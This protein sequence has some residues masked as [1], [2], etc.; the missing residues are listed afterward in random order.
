[1]EL[2]IEAGAAQITKYGEELC[3]DNY[4]LI[5]TAD[6]VI[7]VL[8][9]GL[10]SGVKANILATLT[11][12]ILTT[13][14]ENDCNLDEV[15]AT[16]GHTLPICQVRKVAYSTFTIARIYSD[17]RAY[18]AEFD[19]PKAF[20]LR[21]GRVRALERSQR[22]IDDKVVQE[23]HFQ[24]QEGDHLIFASDGV[25]HAGVGGV[26]NLGWRWESVAEYIERLAIEE[27]DAQAISDWLVMVT[28]QLYVHR[29]GDDA[30]VI[31]MKARAPRSTTVL[32]GPPVNPS[33]DHTVVRELLAEQGKKV[34]CGGT[35]SNI[36]ARETG[37]SISVNLE[38]LTR[39][40]PPTGKIRGIDLVTEGIMTLAKALKLL[41]DRER[42]SSLEDANDGA[43][44]LAH[45]LLS[46]DHVSFLVGRAIN[47]AHQSPS[48]PINLALKMKIVDELSAELA[49]RGK[50]VRMSYY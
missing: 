11:T 18:L 5:R 31:T 7:A 17:G 40:V 43:S 23:A 39:E 22:V 45:V 24:V 41:K 38:T 27:K 25:I 37:S 1:M 48:H 42:Q 33:D 3:G 50:Q 26:L 30:T 8:S 13:M 28:D 10:G 2:F 15:I 49:Q 29:P 46:S 34:V 44:Q 32:V 47:P 21:G 36:V 12:R 6:S 35:T 16:I 4:A 9:D 14:L 19:N 20:F